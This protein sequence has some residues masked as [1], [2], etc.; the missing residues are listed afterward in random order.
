MNYRGSVKRVWLAITILLSVASVVVISSPKI[1]PYSPDSASTIQKIVH[2]IN[3]R[4]RF[5]FAKAVGGVPELSWLEVAQGT[6][7]GQHLRGTWPGSGFITDSMIREGRSL[8][9][10]VVNPLNDAKGLFD[11]KELF[12]T[13]CAGCHGHDA[14]GGGHA[15][16]LVTSNYS[17]GASDFALYKMLRD[18]I[19]GTAMQSLGLSVRERWEIVAFLRSLSRETDDAHRTIELPHVDVSWDMLKAARNLTDSWLVYSGGLD[20]WR[21]SPLREISPLNVSH[22][23]LLWLHQFA[24]SR[25]DSFEATPLVSSKTIFMTE[26]PNSVVAINA[27]NGREIWRHTHPLPTDLPVCCGRVNRGV[28]LLGG[29]LF[30]GTLDAHMLAIDA[31]SG[32][33]KWEVEVASPKDGFSITV[34]PLIV[35]NMVIVGVSG[36]EFG[37]RGFLAAYDAATG[38]EVWRFYTIPGP[39]E[40]GSESWKN[41]AWRSGGG[42]TWITGSYDP[43]LDLLYW[44]VGNPS[45]N[46]TSEVRP[47]DNLFTNSVVALNATT[48]K[49]AWHFQFTPHDEHDWDSNQTPVLADLM[50]DGVSRKVICWANRNGFYYVLDRADGTFLRG[51]PYVKVTWASGLDVHGRPILTSAAKVTKSGTLTWPWVGGGTNWLPPSFDQTTQTF[52]VHATEGSSIFTQSDGNEVRRGAGGLYVGSG[53]SAADVAVNVVKALDAASG[54]LKWQHALPNANPEFSGTYSGILSTEGGVMF[55][56]YAGTI[57]ALEMA[58]GRELWRAGLG[59]KTQATPISFTLNGAQVVAV[60]AGQALFLFGL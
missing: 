28:A 47:G 14:R 52:L 24:G 40:F 46:Y 29:T 17:V 20:G 38:K 30:V 42:P 57:F 16:S 10:S 27:E 7:P 12:Q 54:A 11:G 23:K 32:G 31:A 58:T 44:G 15:P 35:K 39:A 56:T 19:P 50:M 60:T 3:W 59:G 1:F 41:N 5:Y 13:N 55:T 53:S 34:A 2:H 48:G 45:P 36:G 6:W 9:A 18:G 43:D 49:R 37:I 25:E 21:H 51:A 4:I 33:V 26:P 22:L 8:N